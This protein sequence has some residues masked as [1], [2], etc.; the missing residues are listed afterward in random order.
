MV[1]GCRSGRLADWAV[2]ARSG[3]AGDERPRALRPP[4][5][6]L[7]VPLAV[8]AVVA[9]TVGLAALWLT[10]GQPL[11]QLAA[12]VLVVVAHE[13]LGRRRAGAHPEEV[14]LPVAAA[15]AADLLIPLALAAAVVGLLVVLQLG[16]GIDVADTVGPFTPVAPTL[17]AIREVTARVRRRRARGAAPG[18]DRV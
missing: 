9:A 1:V 18:T 7:P 11:V 3:Q 8:A 16:L 12:I 13:R 2:V 5:A 15:P 14:P 6:P 4:T 10:L 17:I